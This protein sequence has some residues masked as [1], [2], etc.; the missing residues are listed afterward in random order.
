MW[1]C[2]ALAFLFILVEIWQGIEIR[3]TSIDHMGPEMALGQIYLN[4]AIPISGIVI[5]YL[6]S[7][8]W[9]LILA[10]PM[11]YF[12]SRV[13]VHKGLIQI[14]CMFIDRF[15]PNQSPNAKI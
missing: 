13:L 11:T 9:M 14:V 3:E 5:L 4:L 7:T 1:V 12:I 15:F 2:T 8:K 6:E 10:I